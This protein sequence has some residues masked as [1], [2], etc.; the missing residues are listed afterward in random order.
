MGLLKY[1]SPAYDVYALAKGNKKP[2]ATTP[3]YATSSTANA[4]TVGYTGRSSLVG[5]GKMLY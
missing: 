5:S 2:A 1:L 4:G 3:S